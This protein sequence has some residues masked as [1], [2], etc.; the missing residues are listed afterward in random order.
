MVSLLTVWQCITC[1]LASFPTCLLWS[2]DKL[3]L[4]VMCGK[5][6]VSKSLLHWCCSYMELTDCWYTEILIT[7]DLLTKRHYWHSPSAT[8]F[9]LLYVVVLIDCQWEMSWNIMIRFNCLA[10][11]ELCEL[12][13]IQGSAVPKII[14]LWLYWDVSSLQLIGFKVQIVFFCIWLKI[15]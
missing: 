13:K 4:S 9:S 3:I 15:S 6:I 7:F 11:C 8:V 5:R 10:H 12:L 1:E 14:P 2:S